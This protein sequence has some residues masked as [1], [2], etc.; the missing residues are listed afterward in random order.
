M[1]EDAM[2]LPTGRFNLFSLTKMTLKRWILGGDHK[3]IWLKK[4]AN[5]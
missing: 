5:V 4:G 3:E 1:M 2:Y